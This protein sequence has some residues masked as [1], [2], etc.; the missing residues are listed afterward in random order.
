M[1]EDG[2]EGDRGGTDTNMVMVILG[3]CQGSRDH[4]AVGDG[5]PLGNG[6]SVPRCHCFW[7]GMD[8]RILDSSSGSCFIILSLH[9][10][11]YDK[12]LTLSH[13]LLFLPAL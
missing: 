6:H 10:T 11:A 1:N 5:V 9:A 2:A 13:T 4:G 7:P 3:S 12:A 8:S